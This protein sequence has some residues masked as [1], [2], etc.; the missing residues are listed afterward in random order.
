MSS[1]PIC[2]SGDFLGQGRQLPTPRSGDGILIYDAGGLR[3]FAMAS[4]YNLHLGC[5]WYLIDGN[6]VRMRPP[7]LRPS[8]TWPATSATSP[9]SPCRASSAAFGRSPPKAPRAVHAEPDVPDHCPDGDDLAAIHDQMWSASACSSDSSADKAAPRSQRP[10]QNT[11]SVGAATRWRRCRP[12]CWLGCNRHLWAAAIV[13]AATS[14]VLL[15]A[16]RQRPRYAQRDEPPASSTF[17]C[18]RSRSRQSIDHAQVVM[19]R[20]S[21]FSIASCPAPSHGDGG[22]RE[23]VPAR[24]APAAP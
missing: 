6:Q 20:G 4:R 18:H 15:I 7:P 1:V 3:L 24:V 9:Q 21:G 23:P 8:T 16:T 5:A 10:S 12:S 2:E 14:P 13:S 11:S 17:L 22:L 19:T